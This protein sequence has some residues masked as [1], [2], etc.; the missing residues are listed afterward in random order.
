[1]DAYLTTICNVVFVFTTL[2]VSIEVP[3]TITNGWI[4]AGH[5]EAT[6]EATDEVSYDRPHGSFR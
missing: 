6:V 3:Q 4:D 2:E 5:R 1:M